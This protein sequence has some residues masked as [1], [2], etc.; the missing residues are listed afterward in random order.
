MPLMPMRMLSALPGPGVARR[1]SRPAGPAAPCGRGRRR[2]AAVKISMRRRRPAYSSFSMADRSIALPVNFAG[3]GSG[4]A[5]VT[6]RSPKSGHTGP[7]SG[8]H[9]VMTKSIFGA[10]GPGE[11]VPGL[12]AQVTG[13]VTEGLQPGDHLGIGGLVRVRSGRPG[14]EPPAAEFLHDRLG[15]DRTR[16]IVRAQEQHV[17]GRAHAFV[18][19]G[20]GGQQAGQVAAQL[21][22]AAAAGLGEEAQQPA[23]AGDPHGVDDLPPLP[24]GLGQPGPLQRGEMEGGRRGGQAEPGGKVTGRQAAGALGQQRAQQVEP[25]V[26]RQGGERSSGLR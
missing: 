16:R 8:S 11:L 7:S 14:V 25:G 1:R 5:P 18:L 13:G 19:V 12:A 3:S 10:F 17:E 6:A 20:Q 26:H 9:R 15:H 24:G 21:R 22:P 23:Q 2:A 4:Q